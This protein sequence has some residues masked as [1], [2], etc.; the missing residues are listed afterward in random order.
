MIAVVADDLTGAVEIAGIGLRHGLSVE[1]AG[2]IDAPINVDLLVVATDTRSA[3]EQEAVQ[4]MAAI[5]SKLK[6]LNPELIFKKIDSVLRGHV[7][8]ELNAHLK[9]LDLQNVLIVPANPALGRTLTSGRYYINGQPIHLSSF[10]DDPEFAITGADVHTLLRCAKHQI[11]VQTADN[12]L[13]TTGIVVGEC[14][15]ENDL[16]KWA[17]KVDNQM[18][19]AG[20]S[21]FFAA[22]LAS[23]G[24]LQQ[25]AEPV[26]SFEKPVLF[27]CGST[28][29]KS[30]QLVRQL[31]DNG[32]PVSY[33]PQNIITQA[34]PAEEL[35]D[36]WADEV[37]TLLNLHHKAVIA[38]DENTIAPVNLREKKAR[39]VQKVLEITAVK[40]L[41]IEGGATAS[42]IINQLKLN[43]F[44]PVYEFSTGVIRM[45]AA[46]KGGLF[47]T[48]K[49]GSYAWPAQ[50]WDF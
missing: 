29:D 11:F 19:L 22:I 23:H 37:I 50:V 43:R 13:P 34:A 12:N 21:S 28:F 24:Y 33:M 40:E 7:L 10:A 3:P 16:K 35:F 4:T 36:Q 20:G 44:T 5:A 48:L 17:A 14:E 18:L 1:I 2:A 31:K 9:Q 49:P 27:I 32:G 47:L 38:V 41:V 42:A 8:A 25:T 45:S 26:C 30:R 6:A 46:Q 15:T 39:L